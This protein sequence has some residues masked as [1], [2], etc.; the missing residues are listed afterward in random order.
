MKKKERITFIIAV[1]LLSLAASIGRPAGL[2]V[3]PETPVRADTPTGGA[4]TGNT[5]ATPSA[6]TVSPT[7]SPTPTSRP[8]A[9]PTP[10]PTASPTPTATPTPTGRI[11][12]TPTSGP[13]PTPTPDVPVE[14]VGVGAYYIGSP[15]EVGEEINPEEI[16]VNAHFSD[17]S[18]EKV[19]EGSYTISDKVINKLGS[20]KIVIVYEGFTD[21]FYIY[22]I[23]L[24]S[25]EAKCDR[26]FYGLYNGIDN[27]DLTVTANYSDN[28]TKLITKGYTIDPEKFTESGSQKVTITYKDCTASVSVYVYGERS[29]KSLSVTYS[30]KDLVEGHEI[31]RNDLTVT[32]IYDDSSLSTER[33]STYELKETSFSAVGENTI[34]VEFLG[35]KAS[36]KVNVIARKIESIRAKYTGGDVEVG[37]EYIASEMHV[38]VLY[39]DE[40]EKEITDYAVYDTIV[41]YIGENTIKIYYGDYNT[42]CKITGVEVAPPDFGYTS[43]FTIRSGSNKFTITTA[44]PKRL[45]PSCIAGSLVK[46]TKVAR[47]YRKLKTKTGWYCAFNFAFSDED[48]DVFY[49]VTVRITVPKTMEAEYTDL[50]YTPNRKSI[51]GRMSKE[52]TKDGEVEVVLFKEGTYLIVYDPEAY[53]E[54]EEEEESGDD[55]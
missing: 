12:P 11:T 23:E 29:V 39:N 30:G 15:V 9:T 8:T 44:I 31:D 27:R 18:T 45:D 47:A 50:Y 3:G 35:A 1:L 17:G 22:G 6:I 43:E 14:V 5:A 25:I 19:A 24:V 16:V 28:S 40:T 49:P 51:T 4:G 54:E 52:V 38:Y 55:E 20:N 33:I 13:S 10:T 53:A 41:R 42:T 46:K 26:T 7:V 34:N 48:Y 2:S 21:Y 36:C 32:A 37:Y